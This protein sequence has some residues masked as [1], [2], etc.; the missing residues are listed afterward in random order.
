MARLPRLHNERDAALARHEQYMLERSERVRDS[1]R[2]VPRL[3]ALCALRRSHPA[4]HEDRWL[5]GEAVDAV[6]A[7]LGLVTLAAKPLGQQLGAPL[8]AITGY[9]SYECRPRNNVA[10]AKLSEHGTGNDQSDQQPGCRS[11]RAGR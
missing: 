5:T 8:A 11:G 1:R 6:V 9:D 3:G 10:G 4:L 2:L 7:C